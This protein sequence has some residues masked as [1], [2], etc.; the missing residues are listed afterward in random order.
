MDYDRVIKALV[1]IGYAVNNQKGSHIVMRFVDKQKYV[2]LF[3]CRKNETMVIVPAHKPLGKGIL[4]TIIREI[5][6]SVEEFN[7]LL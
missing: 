6:L 2:S 4:R 3:G 5:D 1:N 7:K